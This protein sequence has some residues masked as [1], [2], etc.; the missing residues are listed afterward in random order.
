M[1]GWI[2]EFARRVRWR[3]GTEDP[4]R[5]TR[6]DTLLR[7]ECCERIRWLLWASIGGVLVFTLFD[8]FVDRA[9]GA[10]LWVRLAL[11]GGVLA[12]L[13]GLAVALRFSAVRQR[14]FPLLFALCLATLATDVY[15]LGYVQP[16]P[17]RLSFHLLAVYGLTVISIQW[18]WPWQ[19]GLCGILTSLFLL[20]IPPGHPNFGFYV[21]GLGVATLLTTVVAA[22]ITRW[23]YRQFVTEE[24][25]RRANDLA[26]RQSAQLE[27]KNAELT[28]LF[29]VL[30]HDLRAPLINV[31]G[32]TRELESTIEEVEALLDDAAR[33]DGKLS[34]RWRELR[35]TLEESVGF[36]RGGVAKMEKLVDGIL[37]LSRIETR[38]APP[39]PVELGPL[40]EEILRSFHYQISQRNIDVRVSPLPTV[41]GDPVRLGQVFS[42][43]VDNAIKYM[44]PTGE[45]R[46]EIGYLP[47]E[48]DHLFYVRDTGR[49][50]PAEHQEKVFRLFARLHANGV[51]GEGLGLTAVKKIV[52]KHGGTIWLDSD[53]GVGTTVWFTLP[54]LDPG[55][56]EKQEAPAPKAA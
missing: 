20:V 24:R 49:G 29:Y 34:E 10:V 53:P 51:P 16:A 25:L 9:H 46:I 17:G 52:E 27:A 28:D 39:Q 12:A 43:L 38:P 18:P 35:E 30:S 45:A 19:L 4:V 56:A 31:E 15:S 26:A 32:F 3:G 42:N 54:R 40:L 23:R 55:E 7:E 14:V 13:L 11:N 50:I 6:F 1:Q 33:Q 47:G 8:V 41:V 44:K 37:Q 22:V 5:Q 48:E 21:V 36:I 2:E